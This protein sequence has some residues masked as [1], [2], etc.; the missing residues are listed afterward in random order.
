MWLR[1]RPFVGMLMVFV[2][3]VDVFVLHRLV[4]MSV[5]V[6]FGQMEPETHAHQQTG[7][8]KL[9]RNGFVQQQNRDCRADEGREGKVSARARCSKMPQRQHEENKAHPHPKEAKDGGRADCL[10]GR[11]GRA[12]PKRKRRVCAACYY[13]LYGG[14]HDRTGR[15]QLPRQVVVDTPS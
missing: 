2:M 7:R 3:R 5:F 15:R 6:P 4:P 14:R 1:Q 8:N 9:H 12:A 10:Q 11:H 13:A